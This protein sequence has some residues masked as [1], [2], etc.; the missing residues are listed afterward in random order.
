MWRR[1]LRWQAGEGGVALMEK[2][3]VIVSGAMAGVSGGLLA[4]I[5]VGST[6]A[7]ATSDAAWVPGCVIVGG[8]SGLLAGL[9]WAAVKTRNW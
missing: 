3:L 9:I 8:T 6:L 4:A 5:G 7:V 2:T 1:G